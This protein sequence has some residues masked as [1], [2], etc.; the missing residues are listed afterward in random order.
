MHCG[1]FPGSPVVKALLFHRRG[2]RFDP[3]W[4]AKAKKKEKKKEMHLV[5]NSC[6][7]NLMVQA[8]IQRGRLLLLSKC[9]SLPR[10]DSLLRCDS[11][12]YVFLQS[13][14]SSNM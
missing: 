12:W 13:C 14:D 11:G 9:D 6:A 4:G 1:D 8:T 2:H 7:I 5:L 10:C 3:W